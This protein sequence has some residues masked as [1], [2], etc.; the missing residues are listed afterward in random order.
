MEE[1][2]FSFIIPCWEQTHLL[3]CLLQSIWCQT[4]TNWEVIL[5]HDGPNPD[6]EKALGNLIGNSRFKYTNTGVRY[7]YWGHYGR[8]IGTELATGDWII[9]TNDDNYFMPILLQ[10]INDAIIR[11]PESNFVYWEMILGKY[12]NIHSHNKK[13]YGHFIPKIQHSYIDW[14]QFATKSEVIKKY[15]INKHEAAADGT[16]VEDMKHE[17][18][19]VFIDKCLFVHN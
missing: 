19:P 8:E 12:S 5:V 2:K 7:G 14:G 3:K 10:E 13:D 18:N 4:Y 6:H 11:N 9:H 17:L 1:V 16:L 15:S